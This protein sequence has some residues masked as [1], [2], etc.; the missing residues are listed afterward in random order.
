MKLAI[1]SLFLVFQIGV[2]SKKNGFALDHYGKPWECNLFNVFG[3]YCNNQCTENKARKGYCCTFT[4]YCF[5]LPDDAKIL[6]IGD[7][8]KNYCDVSLTDVLG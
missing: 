6:E 4:C 2:E 7:S 1:L 3:P 5:D 8:R